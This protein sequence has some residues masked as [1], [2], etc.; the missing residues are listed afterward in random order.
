MWNGPV[1]R[2]RRVAVREFMPTDFAPGTARGAMGR[3]EAP[4]EHSQSGDAKRKRHEREVVPESLLIV[5]SQLKV[6]RLRAKK[7]VENP[8]KDAVLEQRGSAQLGFVEPMTQVCYVQP[9]P[10]RKSF[11][12]RG[13]L[14]CFP[15]REKLFCA[16]DRSAGA[17]C[18]RRLDLIDVVPRG[19]VWS[20]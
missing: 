7:H 11:A 3:R 18:C 20:A 17:H 6:A 9:G 1:V 5:V 12:G 14:L 13:Q 19:H 15:D 2:D 4:F 10:R 8:A 16:I